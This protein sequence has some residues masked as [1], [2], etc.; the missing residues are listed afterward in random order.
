M[1][2]LVPLLAAIPGVALAEPP[3][4]DAALQRAA[5]EEHPWLFHGHM[6]PICPFFGQPLGSFLAD[7]TR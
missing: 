6:Q 5:Y 7:G 1:F 2:V 4:F 3:P